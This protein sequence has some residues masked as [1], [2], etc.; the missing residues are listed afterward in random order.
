ML[1]HSLSNLFL[2]IVI[3][4]AIWRLISEIINLLQIGKKYY[5][6]FYSVIIIISLILLYITNN[7]SLKTLGV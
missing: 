5:I 4:V 6:L 7:S 1:F 3:W 2:E